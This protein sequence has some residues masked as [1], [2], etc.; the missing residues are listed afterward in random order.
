[1]ARQVGFGKE[2]A[3]DTAVARTKFLEAI[4]ESLRVEKTPIEVQTLRSPSTR[5][6][7]SDQTR[8]VGDIEFICNYQ[9]IALLAYMFLGNVTTTGAGPYTHTSPGA[10]GVDQT[11]RPFSIEVV[12]EDTVFLY[13]GMKMI[14]FG[15]DIQRG[16]EARVRTS[17]QGG[18]A[19]VANPSAT[20]PTFLT[21]NTALPK[22]VT[23]NLDAAAQDAISFRLD[24]AWP[25]D[26]PYVLGSTTYGKE[27]KPNDVLRVAF[28]FEYL[29]ENLTDVYD[30]YIADTTVDIQVVADTGAAGDEVLTINLNKCKIT[31]HTNPTDGRQR[32]VATASGISFYDTDPTE[33]IQIVTINDQATADFT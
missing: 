9:E 16:Q 21:L 22:E 26:D 25:V 31:E 12:R 10:S 1:M 24:C 5:A 33:N 19:N 6:V 20:S 28:S 13:P 17:W 2:V 14:A 27:P 18:S 3:W 8:A 11:R 30:V 7:E 15:L 4:S 23:V 32:Y 29:I